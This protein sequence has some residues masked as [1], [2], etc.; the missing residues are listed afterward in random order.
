V[1]R[2]TDAALVVAA[3]AGDRAALD[4]L[5]RR[6]LPVVYNVVA[7]AMPG[8]PDVDD[9]VQ[10]VMLRA[11]RQLSTLR[12]PA[13]FRA[14]L[15]AIAVH[16]I[17][18][19]TARSDLAARRTAGLDAVAGT[20]DVNADV[21]GPALLRTELATQRR[22]VARA[23]RWLDADDRTL[24]SL[25]WLETAGELSRP[26]IAEA[27]GVSVAHAGVRLQRM[28]DYLESSRA[29]VAALEAVPGCVALDEVIAGWDGRPSQ[30]WRKRIARH[31]RGCR[32]CLRASEGMLATDRLLA[33][34]VLL[35]VP[36]VLGATLLTKTG[37]IG[38]TALLGK[39][40][41]KGW[42]VGKLATAHPVVS[43]IAVG[44]LAVGATVTTGGWSLPAQSAPHAGRSPGATAAS[45]HPGRLSLASANTAGRY[46][47]VSRDL[48][49]LAGA[50]SRQA[51][52][53]AVTGVADGRCFSFRSPDG[54]YLRHAS[55]RIRLDR[56]QGTVLFRRDA[57]FCP[58]AGATT[59]SISLESSNYPG[60]FLRHVGDELWV[61]QSDGS[62]AFRLD[63]SF[64]VRPPLN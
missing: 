39:A 32:T 62:A 19:Q 52:F 33:T 29:T 60:Y 44:S 22:Q 64:V 41:S 48:G 54:R 4:A 38:K 34:L 51:T 28:R 26:E 50:D 27:L 61:D 58:R 5:V 8:R 45:L 59:G 47:A 36:A 21:E 53:D 37:V 2:S 13:S 42:L 35:P 1:D 9:V 63:S 24:F 20:P 40:A 43:V 46:V 6:Y 7:T 56:E 30:F 15:V 17:S 3:R 10:D 55:W 25:W 12:T 49:V 57:T 14:W 16:Q 31:V 18:T 23:S 11:L